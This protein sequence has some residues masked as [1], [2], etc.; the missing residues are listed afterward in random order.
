MQKSAVSRT[1]SH[2][3]EDNHIYWGERMICPVR[4]PII[5]FSQDY[6]ILEASTQHPYKSLRMYS[7]NISFSIK[8]CFPT[9]KN[10]NSKI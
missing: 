10:L 2:I 6:S 8:G 5:Y 9:E 4:F 3:Q 1:V 7:L